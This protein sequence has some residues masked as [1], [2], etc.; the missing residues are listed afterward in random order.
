[1]LD[2]ICPANDGAISRMLQQALQKQG[3][4]FHLSSKMVK[5]QKESAGI[6]MVFEEKGELHE[7]SADVVLVAVGRRPYIAGLGL[8]EIGIKTSPK[9]YVEIDGNFRTSV[10][11]IYAIGDIVEGPMLAHRAS[12]EGIAA[13]EIMA[14]QHPHVNYL[15]IPNVIYTHPEVAAL[16]LTEEEAKAAGLSMKIGTCLFRANSRARCAGETDGM[17][18]VIAEASTGRLIGL[19]IFG[20]HASEMIGIGVVALDQGMTLTELVNVSYAHPTLSE[21][22]KEALLNALGRAIHF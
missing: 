16:G 4:E 3:L 15:A 9:G 18:K 11:N 7:I 13:A 10:P 2:K 12:E 17:V 8:A 1:M 5:A 19:H 21:A 6:S 22:I 20:A 14:G